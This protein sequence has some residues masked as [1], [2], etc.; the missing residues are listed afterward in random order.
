MKNK[1]LPKSCNDALDRL[2]DMLDEESL[3]HSD[4]QLLHHRFPE[5]KE[6]I[7]DTLETWQ[8]MDQLMTPEPSKQMRNDFYSMLG[9]FTAKHEK[10]KSNGFEPFLNFLTQPF[11][12]WALLPAIFVFGLFIG[13][14]INSGGYAP[15]A[16]QTDSP[17][18]LMQNLT[19]ESAAERLV[20]IQETKEIKSPTEQIIYALHQTLIKDPNV[21]VRLSALEALV[22]FAD[23]PKVRECLINSIPY[24]HSAIV[25]LTLAEVMIGLEEKNSA[26]K[27]KQLLESDEV[28]ADVR[29]HL[30]QTL[31]QIL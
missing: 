6:I 16:N 29:I 31:K 24:Q 20:S 2:I 18:E 28:E 10:S 19:Q 30:E 14:W 4:I 12:K 9:D 7:N 21:N 13:N 23:Q 8:G 1:P 26:E 25:Q 3:T 11:L 22:H 27:W 17:N 5:C 15:I